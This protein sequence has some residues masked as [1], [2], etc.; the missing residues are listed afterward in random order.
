MRSVACAVLV[1]A[2]IATPAL[3]EEPS[4]EQC[5][6][7]YVKGQEARRAGK[8]LDA[9]ASFVV[10]G[11]ASCP[12]P[13]AGDCRRWRDEVEA[14]IPTI[15]FDVVDRLGRRPTDVRVS[16]D[17]APFAG[18]I[19]GRALP[20]DPGAHVFVFELSGVPP[21]RVEAT[22]LE[23]IKSQKVTLALAPAVDHRDTLPIM[24]TTRPIPAGAWLAGGAAIVGVASFAFFGL[25]ANSQESDLRALC[26]SAMGCT[27]ADVQ[28]G[29]DAIHTKQIAADISLGVGVVSLGIAEWLFAT[30]PTVTAAPARVGV[31]P[32]SGGWTAEAVWRF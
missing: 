18:K 30:R 23:G 13:F 29:R 3:A 28:S 32:A 24:E 1:V 20:I 21:Q 5:V 17:G 8:L 12:M 6:D 10:C 26:A 27:D 9:R 16:A 15:V 19:D 25:L 7:A 11:R 2:A 14:A 22:I 31:R 4:K